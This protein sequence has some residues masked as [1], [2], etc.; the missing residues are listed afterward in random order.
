MV[1]INWEYIEINAEQI[2][3]KNTTLYD[4]NI[5][6]IYGLRVIGKGKVGN[7]MMCEILNFSHPFT[8]TSRMKCS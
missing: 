4:L 6:L 5:R 1:S 3:Y 2:N 8:D 7:D